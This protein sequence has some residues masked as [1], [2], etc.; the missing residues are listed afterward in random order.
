VSHDPWATFNKPAIKP[1]PKPAPQPQPKRKRANTKPR[2]PKINMIPG[3]EPL[4]AWVSELRAHQWDAINETV[5]LLQ[6]NCDVVFIDAPTGSGKTLIG[7]V[8]RRMVAPTGKTMY[9]CSSLALQDQFLA[10][11]DYAAVLKGRSNYTPTSAPDGVNCGDCNKQNNMCS[12]CPDVTD[13]EY[14]TAKRNAF[15]SDL[16][17]VNTAYLLNEINFVGGFAGRDL[18]VVDEA[19]VLE[20]EL[21]RFVQFEISDRKLASLKVTPPKKGSHMS[22]IFN[23]MRTDLTPALSAQ[24]ATMKRSNAARSDNPRVVREYQST[25]RLLADVIRVCDGVSDG[26]VR[27]NNAGQLV[28]K[29]VRVDQFGAKQLWGHANQWVCMSATIISPDE[30][31]ETLGLNEAGLNW[32]VVRVPMTFDVDNRVIRVAG[33]ANMV[34]RE[35]ETEWPKMVA[36]VRNVLALHPDERILV[37]TVSYQLAEYLKQKLTGTGRLLVTYPTTAAKNQAIAKFR[38]TPNSVMLAP[39]LD[40]GVDFKDDDCRVVVVAKVPFPNLGDTQ[41]SARL[42]APGGKMWY[43]VQTVR[44][45]VQ[46]TGRGVRSET[47]WCVTYILDRQFTSNVWKNNRKLFPAWWREAVDMTFPKSKLRD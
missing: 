15:A 20:Q 11:F 5:E 4:P 24:L 29:P 43:A 32:G 47:D 38:A 26:W 2:D 42:H 21:M 44:S 34:N 13:C 40:R 30:M 33:V 39:S 27:D 6:T 28:L 12:W 9:V 22:T 18:V 3:K 36:A 10:D 7:E 41:V 19:D 31:A 35:K 46:M 45:L 23:W 16:A 1:K 8:T 25:N 37:H 14:E 17:V